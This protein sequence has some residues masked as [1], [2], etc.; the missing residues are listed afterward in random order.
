MSFFI[1]SGFLLI[2]LISFA[3]SEIVLAVINKVFVSRL[4]T[5]RNRYY[6]AHS[7]L[8]F[9]ICMA[10]VFLLTIVFFV[11]DRFILVKM[12]RSK[13]INQLKTK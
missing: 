1:F 9:W 10:G 5:S 4:S 7:Y 11:L 8:P 3:I 6:F 2:V 12:D 13:E